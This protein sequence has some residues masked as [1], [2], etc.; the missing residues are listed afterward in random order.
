M[1]ETEL[2]RPQPSPTELNQTQPSPTDLTTPGDDAN[3]LPRV[4]PQRGKR[5]RVLGKGEGDVLIMEIA[6]PSTQLPKGTLTPIPGVPQF[7]SK[8]E[9]RRWVQADSKDLL[10]NKQIMIL[11]VHDI[12]SVQVE[13][14]PKVALN[15]KQKIQVAGPQGEGE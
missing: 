9:A 11:Q 5:Y 15:W 10:A 3:P 8:G 14:T 13:A 12:G 7:E 2:N 4:S 6:P 1:T